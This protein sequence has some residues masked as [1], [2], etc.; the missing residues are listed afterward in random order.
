MIYVAG[1]GPGNPKYMTLDVIDAIR[2]A[3]NVVAFNRVSDS[4]KNIR[5]DYI[6]VS[7]VKEILNCIEDHKDVLIL[8][9]G[10]PCFYGILDYLKKKRNKGR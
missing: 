5:N 10:D 9:S 4:I 2:D 3:T 7:T 8:A 1:V 6:K